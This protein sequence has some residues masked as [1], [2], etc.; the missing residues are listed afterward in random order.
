MEEAVR[1]KC[2]QSDQRARGGGMDR[3]ARRNVVKKTL[4]LQVISTKYLNTNTVQ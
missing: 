1:L 2:D 4:L 3:I